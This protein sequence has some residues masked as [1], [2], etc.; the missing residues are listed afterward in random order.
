M[1]AAAAWSVHLF[2]ASGVVLALLA[3]EATYSGEWRLALLW[4]LAALAIDGVDGSL[5]RLARVKE[6]VPRIDG[7]AFDLIVDYL[8]YVFVPAIL[9]ARAGLV[10]PALALPLAAAILLSSVYVFVRKDMKTEDNY[11]RG[12]P[13]LWNVVALY[14]FAAQPPAEAGAVI[15][16]VLAILSFAPVRFVHPFRVAD[17]QPWLKLV[18]LAWAAATLALLWPGWSP[19]AGRAWLAASLAMAAVLVALGLVRSLRGDPPPAAG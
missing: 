14:L 9:I 7:E 11:F 12:F 5:A 2:T 3:L 4:L 18:A 10:P 13:A 19:A 1:R 8:N 16:I 17:W 6:T 15:V